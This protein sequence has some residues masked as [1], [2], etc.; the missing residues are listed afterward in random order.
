MVCPDFPLDL[1]T[2]AAEFTQHADGH[3]KPSLPGGKVS[4]AGAPAGCGV[5]IRLLGGLPIR[6]G[7]LQKTGAARRFRCGH[8]GQP[9]LIGE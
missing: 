3:T 6:E 2:D 8:H 9:H 5:P 4:A 1:I 7:L